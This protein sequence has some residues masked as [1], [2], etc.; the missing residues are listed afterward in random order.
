MV[1]T[2]S[3]TIWM[4]H[5]ATRAAAVAS[6]DW[7]GRGQQK[8]A[9]AA[10]VDAMRAS[11]NAADIAG[12]VVIGEG[13]RDEAPMLYIGEDV[14]QG[15]FGVDIALDPLEGTALC[16]EARTGSMAVLAF[17][18]RGGLLHAPDVY[19]EKIA[20]PAG[21]DGV[22]ELDF[23]VHENIARLAEAMDK[24]IGE[25]SV[26]VLK[27]ERHQAIIEA[28]YDCGARL[29]LID[30]GDIAA[31]VQVATKAGIDLYLGNGGAPEGV[32]SAAACKCLGGVFQGRLLFRNDTERERAAKWG[33][34]DLAR[35]YQR[36]ELVPGNVVFAA[37]GVT[38][39]PL[40]GG[41]QHTAEGAMTQTL[42]LDSQAQRCLLLEEVRA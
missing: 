37:T 13:E 34:T 20:A 11:L 14:G 42:L 25:L 19:M 15:T 35:K 6:Y 1:N 39:G 27:R 36:D 26:C 17:A 4:A 24:R 5:E 28:V 18:E 2:I 38:D 22:V 12:R 9:D 29:V 10:A 23:S 31:S 8:K 32:L 3:E 41:V 30:D 21:Y 33:V 7:I 16:A 40:V